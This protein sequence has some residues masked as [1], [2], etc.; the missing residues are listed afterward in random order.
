MPTEDKQQQQQV[1]EQQQV[2]GQQD[3]VSIPVHRE[4]RSLEQKYRDL[5]SKLGGKYRSSVTDGNQIQA[6]NTEWP[7][8]VNRWIASTNR[9]WSDVMRRLWQNAFELV[10]A[11]ISYLDPL[12]TMNTAAPQDYIQAILSHMDRQTEAVR[13]EMSQFTSNMLGGVMPGDEMS[14][15]LVPQGGLIGG[16][17]GFLKDAF[18]MGEDGKVKFRLQFDM[19]GYAP[20]DVEVKMKKHWL[21]V[22]AKK[23]MKTERGR[24]TSEFCRTVYVPSS[25]DGDNF[26][27]QLTNDGILILEA[28]VKHDDY[29]QIKFDRD[30]KLGI[31]PRSDR[32]LNENQPET[33]EVESTNTDLQVTGR[34]SPVIQEGGPTNRTLHVEIPIEPGFTADDLSIRVDANRLIV[35]G[36]HEMNEDTDKYCE[37]SVHEFSRSYV[38]PETVDPFSMVSQLRGATLVVEAP[39][40]RSE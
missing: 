11:E 29:R 19:R 34:F 23:T 26:Q 21:T 6:V 30:L 24:N 2:Q 35:T 18:Q 4:K 39:L 33:M 1:Q 20:E 17:L 16:P 3:P 31:K 10:P 32:Q 25:V 22:Q 37:R 7:S 38:V 8:E 27:C 15:P 40:V 12:V 9:L 5:V 13:K 14:G 28:P 36:R